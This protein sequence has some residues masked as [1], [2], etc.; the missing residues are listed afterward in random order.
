MVC[1]T[2]CIT[3]SPRFRKFMYTLRVLRL[4]YAEGILPAGNRDCHQCVAGFSQSKYLHCRHETVEG[5][6]LQCFLQMSR[7]ELVQLELQYVPLSSA[8]YRC[9]LGPKL[10]R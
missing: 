5:T 4:Q 7:P 10:Y 3:P 9:C 8:G 1:I 6:S 2:V